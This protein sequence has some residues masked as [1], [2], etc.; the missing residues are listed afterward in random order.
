MLEKDFEDILCNNPQLIEKD[1]K[2]LDRQVSL[3]GKFADLLFEDRFGQKL[4]VELKKG[5]IKREHIAQLLDYEGYFLSSDDPNIRVMLIGNRVPPNLQKS[6]DH[7]GFEW[8]EIPV[9][10]LIEHLRNNK[11][12]VMLEKFINEEKQTPT[13]SVRRKSASSGIRITGDRKG[14][15]QL[16]QAT[17][18]EELKE[19][20]NI[21]SLQIPSCHMDKLLL[22]NTNKTIS[23]ILEEDWWPYAEKIGDR[24]FSDVSKVIKHLKFREERGWEYEYSGNRKDPIVRLV[25]FKRE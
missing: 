8:K 25:G 7:H 16:N 5:I 21:R 11:E 12:D 13:N 24:H 15:P 1:L 14:L 3:G 23:R 17:S 10:T 22:E 4:V 19:I 20:I 2:F 18:F 9:S 6:L